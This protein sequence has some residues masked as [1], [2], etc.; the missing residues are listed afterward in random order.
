M[1]EAQTQTGPNTEIF[2]RLL[3]R[4]G[5]AGRLDPAIH[6]V[7]RFFG[8]RLDSTLRKFGFEAEF[9][10]TAHRQTS[11]K[12]AL[13][14]VDAGAVCAFIGAQASHPLAFLI[15]DYPAT[16]VVAELIL[17]GDPEFASLSASRAPTAMECELLRQ[18]GDFVGEALKTTLSVPENPKAL[19]IIQKTE[20]IRDGE[21]EEPVVV[22]DVQLTF[23]EAKPVLS[24]A[25][26]HHMMLQMARPIQETVKRPQPAPGPDRHTESKETAPRPNRNA[27]SVKVPVT[28]SIQLPPITLGALRGLRVGDMLPLS[29]EGNANVKLK[30]KG[31]PL[32]DCSLGRKGANYAMC[33]EHPHEAMADALNGIGLAM[34]NTDSEETYDE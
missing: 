21:D 34:P 28:G 19:R 31:K 27:L 23:G 26:T 32:Y 13:T 33:L 12:E 8:E 4:K 2:D 30:V 10:I 15:A 29:D 14:K 9:E 11:A 16:S 6:A 5:D 22:F 24:L 18:F 25:I 17:G 3:G 20:E 1:S 7:L